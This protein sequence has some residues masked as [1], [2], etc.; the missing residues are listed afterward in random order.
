MRRPIGI[1]LT[2]LF[3]AL[4]ICV[5]VAHVLVPSAR[6]AHTQAL[7]HVSPQ[8]VLA[9]HVALTA[10]VALE[11]ITVIFYWLGRSWARW[12]VLVGCI[13]YLTGL[14]DLRFFW[15]RS[16]WVAFFAALDA[17]LA[18]FL[19]WYLHWRDVRTWFHQRSNPH[20]TSTQPD[21]PDTPARHAPPAAPVM[22]LHIAPGT[23]PQP[24]A[25]PADAHQETRSA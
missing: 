15:G 24:R 10:F 25:V 23:T 8:V 12:F 19:L 16:P 17:V 4:T 11:C 18:I 6:P 9:I 5:D 7:G 21:A 14:K 13:Y 3:M 20:A 22:S 2:A 1:S